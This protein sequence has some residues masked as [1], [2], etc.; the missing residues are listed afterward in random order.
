MKVVRPKIVLNILSFLAILLSLILIVPMLTSLYFDDNGFIGFVET[1]L[2]SLPI[3]LAI[4]FFTRE[5]R[6]LNLR[7]G[8]LVVALGWIV[9][10]FIGSLPYYF[11]GAIPTLTDSF[12]ESMSGFTTTGATILT[13]IEAL[14][15]SLHLWRALTHWIGGMGIIVLSIAILPLLGIG[16]M[17]LFKAE[18]PGPTAD[19]LTPRVNQTAKI[20]WIVY[21]AITCL[22][23]ILLKLGGMSFFDS[24]CHSFA[25]M[26]TGGFSTQNGSVADYNSAYIDYVITIFMFIA[27][28]NF[29]LHYKFFLKKFNVHLK[30]IEFRTYFYIVMGVALIM[31]ISNIGGDVY[32]SFEESFR[33]AI[34]QSVAII[35]TTGFGTADYEQWT[36]LSQILIFVL[37]FV[38]GSAGSTGGGMKVIRVLVIIK[39]G[40]LEL[41]KLVHPNAIMQ[42]RVGKRVIPQNVVYSILGFFLLYVLIF[43]IITITMGA[44]GLDLLTAF[45]AS[46]SCLGN[47][48]PG[49]GI[50][51]PTE[52]YFLI[53]SAGKWV[54]SF[55]MLVGRLEIYT[56]LVILTGSFWKK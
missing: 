35:T 49:F 8:F 56:V 16:G 1:I 15:D 21:F 54:L 45:G 10:A 24:I 5:K 6:E 41:K 47:I 17:Q 11:S 36:F 30:D 27:G 13:D 51:G 53:P 20:L 28:A 33:Y 48:G 50:V 25:T 18:V 32:Q 39:E 34:F 42:L 22:E 7:E 23:I 31:T 12:F 43:V 40:L 3:S 26:A 44:L 14:P 9:I 52:N 4:F 37:M 38:G 29:A 19:K 46:A 2:F 55:T